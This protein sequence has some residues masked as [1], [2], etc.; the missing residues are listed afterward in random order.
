MR[1]AKEEGIPIISM[2]IKKND[3]GAIPQELKGKRV[4][5]WSWENLEQFITKL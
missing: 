3:R 5:L 4:I 2:H 1:C